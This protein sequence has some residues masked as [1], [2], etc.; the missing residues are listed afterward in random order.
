MEG[1]EVLGEGVPS[2]LYLFSPISSLFRQL[3]FVDNCA[4][5][6]VALTMTTIGL[7]IVL[8][9]ISTVACAQDSQWFEEFRALLHLI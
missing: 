8:I 3:L 2:S 9:T 1:L 6:I 4:L 5:L 7:L